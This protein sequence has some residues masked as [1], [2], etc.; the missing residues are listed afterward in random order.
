MPHNATL[1]LDAR[2]DAC[3]RN[4]YRHD[5]LKDCV[6]LEKVKDHFIFNIES[7]GAIDPLNMVGFYFSFLYFVSFKSLFFPPIKRGIYFLQNTMVVGGGGWLLG[8]KGN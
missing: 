5:D 1:Q 4:V 2:N 7:T 8:E 3:S 6:E